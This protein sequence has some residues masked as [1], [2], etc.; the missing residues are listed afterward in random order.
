MEKKLTPLQK[1]F[2]TIVGVT[3]VI[4]LY[5]VILFAA[6]AFIKAVLCGSFFP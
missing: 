3:P 2:L 4:I 5:G 6:Y 1:F